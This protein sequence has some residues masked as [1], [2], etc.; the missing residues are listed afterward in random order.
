MALNMFAIE[1]LK[2]NGGGRSELYDCAITLSN[3]MFGLILE[4]FTDIMKLLL[5]ESDES[6][7][8]LTLNDD[9]TTL[10]PAI[11]VNNSNF[12]GLKN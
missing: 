2:T 5:S 3:H 10:L 9:A 11:K 6:T 1:N 4:K 8:R 12:L 7:S